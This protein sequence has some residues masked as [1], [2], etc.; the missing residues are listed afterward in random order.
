MGVLHQWRVELTASLL[1]GQSGGLPSLGSLDRG[2]FWRRFD[3]AAPLHLRLGLNLAGVAVAGV[4]PRLMGH[5]PS[6]GGLEPSAQDAVLLR[7]TALPGL[8]DLVEVGK[9][10]ACFAYFD[11]ARVQDAIRSTP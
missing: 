10:V 2:D 4:L 7:A 5:L 11:D 8:A 3:E 1:P 6:L 9:I